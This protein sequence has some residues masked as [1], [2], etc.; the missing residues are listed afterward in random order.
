[1]LSAT[2]DQ[3]IRFENR[4]ADQYID[5]SNPAAVTDVLV[6]D[7][8]TALA[9]TIHRVVD[10]LSA[11]IPGLYVFRF[12]GSSLSFGDRVTVQYR[13][14]DALGNVIDREVEDT[15]CARADVGRIVGV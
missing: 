14:T 15:V 4:V 2:P 10:G 7:V 8:P 3:S 1:M 6:N 12:D 9:V 11:A 13:H 5:H